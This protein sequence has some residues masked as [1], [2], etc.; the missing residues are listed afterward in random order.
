[1]VL[2]HGLLADGSSWSEVIPRLQSAGLNVA[3]VQNSLRTLEA[4]VEE[5]RL[6][7]ALQDGPTILVG[8]SF[9]G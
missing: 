8:L 6:T 1:M 7:L 3:S 2:V 4:A 5:T 9:F